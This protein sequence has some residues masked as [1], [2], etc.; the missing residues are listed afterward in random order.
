MHSSA[1]LEAARKAG[2]TAERTWQQED[3]RQMAGAIGNQAFA[4]AVATARAGT[5]MLPA[6][7][8]VD[9]G[10]TAALAR[11]ADTRRAL[12]RDPGDPP[13]TNSSAGSAGGTPT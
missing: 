5:A 2:E 10:L 4:R 3:A 7:G 13:A 9:A 11:S 12:A 6:A 8:P 1:K